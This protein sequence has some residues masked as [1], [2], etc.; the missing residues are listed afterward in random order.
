M[1]E[2]DPISAWE[3]AI[4]TR[5]SSWIV[6]LILLAFVCGMVAPIFGPFIRKLLRR[7]YV[8]QQNYEELAR[9]DMSFITPC[10]W[11]WAILCWA[12]VFYA[13]SIYP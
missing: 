12:F 3:N 7:K 6:V 11:I 9:Q 1:E 8:M 13:H 2:H 5:I 10:L 4:K